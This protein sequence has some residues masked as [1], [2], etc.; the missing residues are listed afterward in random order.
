MTQRA[1]QTDW[2][3][4]LVTGLLVLAMLWPM[5]RNVDGLPLSTYPMYSGARSETLT[6]LTAS[7]IT[8]T[9]E[10]S[11]LSMLQVAQTR[12]PLIAQS[13]LNNAVASGSTDAVCL[14]IAGRAGTSFDLV[15]ISRERHDIVAYARGDTSLVD[16]E[17][18][19][20]C[21]APS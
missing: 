20:S 11:P 2:L 19:A 7:G 4:R 13:F 15:E 16:R 12:D 9:G 1:L 8:T 5:V 10:R 6:L 14:E 3:R 18:L 21:E 17:R